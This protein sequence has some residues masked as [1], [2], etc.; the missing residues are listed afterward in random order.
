MRVFAA[1]IF[2]L[3][4]IALAH[5]TTSPAATHAATEP[6]AD[7]LA[8]FEADDARAAFAPG[9]VVFVG[10]S[11]VR[12]WDTAAAFPELR[13]VNRGFGG[14]Q[15]EHALRHARELVTKHKPRLVV[16]YEGDNDLDAGKTPATVADEV[17]RFIERLAAECPDAKLVIL[18]V[19]PSIARLHLRPQQDDLNAR[20]RAL[21]DA[22]AGRVAY[23]DGVGLLLDD[24]GQPRPEC[25]VEDG[26]HLSAAGYGRWNT[27]LRP[28]LAELWNGGEKP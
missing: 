18:S 21:A 7:E 10:S 24:A 28:T 15:M 12:L 11:T 19:K 26:L 8:L 9:G 1:L 14:S 5:P 16:L 27:A 20:F 6:F 2:V 17:R 13:S 23:F 3:A 4:P 22:S 25:Y